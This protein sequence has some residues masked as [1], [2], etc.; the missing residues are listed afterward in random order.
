L[1]QQVREQLLATS[2]S[3][4]VHFSL[5]PALNKTLH[6]VV[7]LLVGEKIVPRNVLKNQTS[8]LARKAYKDSDYTIVIAVMH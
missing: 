6:L 3:E 7:I 8:Q 4:Q 1:Q 2:L 5:C